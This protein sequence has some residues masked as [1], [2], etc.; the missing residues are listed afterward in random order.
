MISVVEEFGL[1]AGR[2]WSVLNSCG[3]LSETQLMEETSLR[4]YEF[5]AAVGWLAR[6]NKICKDGGVYKL[7]ETNL[8]VK[9][10]GDAGK[11]WRALGT[12]GEVDA[13]YISKLI[14]IEGRDIYSAIGWLAREDKVQL[15]KGKQKNI[16]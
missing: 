10:G 8:T 4:D 9:I 7:D 5:H 16:K 3:P 1:N 14:Q 6:E 2:I 13:T 15:K 12:E 11:I